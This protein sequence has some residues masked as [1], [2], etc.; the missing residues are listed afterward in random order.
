MSDAAGNVGACERR[1]LTVTSASSRDK[2]F[3]LFNA[4]ALHS[5]QVKEVDHDVVS[6]QA[7]LFTIVHNAGWRAKHVAHSHDTGYRYSKRQT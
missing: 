7:I 3:C 1:R 4:D 2:T 6:V 5:E